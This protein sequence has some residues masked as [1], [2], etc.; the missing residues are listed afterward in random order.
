MGFDRRHIA[1]GEVEEIVERAVLD[2]QRPLHIGF[3]ER[4]LRMH[5]QAAMQ[6]LVMQP[7]RDRRTGRAGK[8]VG[9]AVGVD[10][11]QRANPDYIS[12]K[13]CRQHGVCRPSCC[14]GRRRFAA[15]PPRR[16]RR[17]ASPGVQ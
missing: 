17:G 3:A 8:A 7:H 1:P 5:Q 14:R 12:E 6:R 13:M 9:R 15:A 10:H 11:P 2:G 16:R 4:Q